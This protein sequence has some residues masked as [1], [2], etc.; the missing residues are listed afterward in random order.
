MRYI[1]ASDIHGC[2]RQL[3]DILN[4]VGYC[5]EDQ[6]IVCGDLFDRGPDSYGVYTEIKRQIEERKVPPILIRGNHEQMLFDVYA[7]VS[8]KLGNRWYNTR[9]W[10]AN[11]GRETEASF[12]ENKA[13]I[14]TA[15][16]FLKNI[17]T[18]S[19]ETDEF[20]AVH[21]NPRDL[22]SPHTCMWD[23][24]SIFHNDYRGKIAVAG[25]TPLPA[26]V[27]CDGSRNEE[28]QELPYG[29]WIDLPEIGLIAIDTGG[30]FGSCFTVAII[31]NGK[32]RFEKV[33]GFR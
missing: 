8:G 11:G 27:Y 26:P 30:V 22:G 17:C 32:I 15:A 18:F 13:N 23:T 20:I 9:V 21:G 5:E 19:Y 4:L 12:K 25:H 3:F 14:A 7:S 1:L 10:Y 33:C 16:R 2:Y 24:W 6:L 28:S 29:E 31:E